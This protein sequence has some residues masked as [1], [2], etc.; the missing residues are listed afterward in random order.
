MN[1]KMK[2]ELGIEPRSVRETIVDMGYSVIEL[3]MVPR[4]SGYLGHPSTRTQ[5]PD[6]THVSSDTTGGTK[7]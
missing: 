2:G 7:Q 3:N 6:K 1:T 5:S 4:R